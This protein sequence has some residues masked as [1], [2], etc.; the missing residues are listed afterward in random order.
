MTRNHVLADR[1]GLSLLE[2]LVALAIFMLSV[3][4]ISQMVDSASRTAR[5][6]QRLSQASLLCQSVMAEIA[7]GATPMVSADMVP[8]ETAEPGW[9]YSITVEP[10]DWTSVPIDGQSITGLN[11]VHVTVQYIGLGTVPE[12]EHTLT[13]VLLDPQLRVPAAEPTITTSDSGEAGSG[14]SAGAS[15][16]DQ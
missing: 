16:G 2:V 7:C 12:V 10:E 9:F 11:T 4:A 8:I 3:V 6:A 15:A 1:S 13:R 5:R 14:A